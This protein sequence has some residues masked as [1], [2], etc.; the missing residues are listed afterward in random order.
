MKKTMCMASLL[1]AAGLARAETYFLKANTQ[2]DGS[3]P[4]Q[5]SLTNAVGTEFTV[6][7][8][9]DGSEGDPWTFDFSAL[10]PAATI[11]D[12]LG[13][14][15]YCARDGDGPRAHISL[16]LNDAD[17]V[18]T[19]AE[20]MN[21]YWRENV[22]SD[23]LVIAD[24]GA[25]AIGGIDAR[26]TGVASGDGGLSIAISAE[27]APVGHVRVGYLFSFGVGSSSNTRMSGG[28][29]TIYGNGHVRIANATGE[30]GDILAYGVRNVGRGGHVTVVHRGDFLVGNIDTH[31][32]SSYGG[33]SRG[34]GNIEL[35]GGDASGDAL[36]AGDLR[37]SQERFR[38]WPRQYIRIGNYRN[39]TILGDIVGYSQ[40]DNS[41]GSGT[42]VIM[43]NNIANI[44]IGG[45]IDLELRVE[46]RQ[47][48]SGRLKLAAMESITLAELDVGKVE[49]ASL[50]SG[51]GRS[52][53]DGDLLNFDADG[54]GSGTL[55]NPVV[56]TQTALR[57]PAGQRLLYK[58]R[59]GANTDLEGKVYRIANED[60]QAGQGGLLMPI[61]TRG[62]I[63][64]FF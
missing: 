12:M 30:P 56:T 6:T 32:P 17:L 21:L 1:L 59:D 51:G 38:D 53:I 52:T 22:Y 34:P 63:I 8:T 3:D 62:T 14:R 24:A 11:V 43:T 39:V 46:G 64:G 15:L 49:F 45:D 9:G 18:G 61:P 47:H 50:S 13:H 54:S 35:D 58:V 20:S 37:T 48:Q 10:N 2:I 28:H 60:G 19:N 4:V 41:D 36:V 31:T 40:R 26:G 42:D 25:I 5:I 29:A 23:H 55:N 16:K 33:S 57:A 44:R 7:R 27:S